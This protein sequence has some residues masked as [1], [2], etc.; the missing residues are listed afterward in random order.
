MNWSGISRARRITVSVLKGILQGN[1]SI[2]RDT[3]KDVWRMTIIGK[4]SGKNS[5]P[6]LAQSIR[7]FLE[8]RTSS[9]SR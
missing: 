1:D 5:C 6:P 3:R 2:T 9:N 8:E 7:P 4:V